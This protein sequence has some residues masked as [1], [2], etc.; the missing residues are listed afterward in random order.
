LRITINPEAE[1]PLS[2]QLV[3]GNAKTLDKWLAFAN[4]D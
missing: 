3:L 4:Q 1:N 2:N